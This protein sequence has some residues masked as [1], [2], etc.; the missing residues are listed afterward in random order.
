MKWGGVKNLLGEETHAGLW[1]FHWAK[2]E[3]KKRQNK[4]R[5]NIRHKTNH[6]KKK[7]LKRKKGGDLFP[8]SWGVTR[9]LGGGRG[10][11]IKKPTAGETNY[12]TR[13][14]DI[15]V[16]T[17][18]RKQVLKEMDKWTGIGTSEYE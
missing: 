6:S 10:P 18:P 11:P 17:R 1:E 7:Q 13:T 8:A 15:S 16:P 9:G 2:K 12:Q 4:H 3:T 14:V 5:N